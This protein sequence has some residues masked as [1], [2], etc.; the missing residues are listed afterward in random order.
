VVERLRRAA[1]AGRRKDYLGSPEVYKLHQPDG[2]QVDSPMPAPE[3]G[4]AA[5]GI[6]LFVQG[7]VL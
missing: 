3:N 1:R 5:R 4:P 2:M 6:F 7:V